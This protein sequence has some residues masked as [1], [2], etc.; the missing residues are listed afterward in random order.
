MK[1]EEN[2]RAFKVFRLTTGT[3]IDHIPQG[4][5]FQVA[6]VLG[7][8]D[9]KDSFISIGIN[10]DSRKYGFKDIIKIENKEFGRED[11]DRIAL[12]APTATLNILKDNNVVHKER[13][14]IPDEIDDMIK[15]SNPMCIT[16]NELM[17]TKFSVVSKSPIKIFCRYCERYMG[18]EDVKFK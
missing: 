7:L 14:Q 17:K 4:R 18:E 13:A 9:I 12:I 2:K 10:L 8:K 5:A 6:D 3:V 16:N 1:I 11:I 15:C